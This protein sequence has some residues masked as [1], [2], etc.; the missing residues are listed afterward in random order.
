MKSLLAGVVS[1]D[2]VL[3]SAAALAG[4]NLAQIAEK[5]RARATVKAHKD[6]MAR[7][8]ARWQDEEGLWEAV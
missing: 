7:L 8:Q 4:Q 3:A 1:P 2:F 6:Q 5:E